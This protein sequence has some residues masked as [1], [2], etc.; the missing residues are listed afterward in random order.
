MDW[1]DSEVPLSGGGRRYCG[2][3][4]R[5]KN[6][7]RGKLTRVKK[8]M[9]VFP[10]CLLYIYFYFFFQYNFSSIF[11]ST[12]MTRFYTLCFTL[13]AYFYTMQEYYLL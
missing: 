11:F 9:E 13:L 3:N 6:G 10:R 8:Q 7:L 2:V 4:Q 5:L 12:G 1:E